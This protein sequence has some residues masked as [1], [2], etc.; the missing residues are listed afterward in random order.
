[1]R[2]LNILVGAA[3]DLR[4]EVVHPLAQPSYPHGPRNEDCE[5]SH[6]SGNSRDGDRLHYGITAERTCTTKAEPVA[7]WSTCCTVVVMVVVTPIEALVTL[8]NE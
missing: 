2:L 4:F 7:I 8:P 6:K 1:M 3:F 5:N